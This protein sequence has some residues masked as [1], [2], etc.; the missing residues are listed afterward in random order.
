MK[1]LRTLVASSAVA[2]AMVA[3]SAIASGPA[4]A[5]EA[6]WVR[7][8]NG[9]YTILLQ[10][11]QTLGGD[12]SVVDPQDCST[13]AVL[14]DR[15]RTQARRQGTRFAA[16]AVIIN[17]IYTSEY[18]RTQET[19]DL[20]FGSYSVEV[21]QELDPLGQAEMS[22]EEQLDAIIARIN[23]FRGPGNQL[24]ITHGGVVQALT[25]TTPRDG[26]AVIVG[27]VPEGSD[28]P[29]VVGRILLN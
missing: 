9:G 10:H 26:E 12:A 3:G 17:G 6:A 29:A 14:S 8:S 21:L 24:F 19:A 1:K 15:G 22:E 2:I 25:G 13:Q 20:A 7:L 28:R 4:L 18:C 16:R 27:P 11:S 5:T 23:G